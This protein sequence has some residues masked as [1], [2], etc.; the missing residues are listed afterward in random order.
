MTAPLTRVQWDAVK[1]A[2][3]DLAGLE[4]D[5]RSDHLRRLERD[6]PR[7]HAE[8]VALL[9]AGDSVGE[10]F[11]RGARV[12]PD[13][14]ADPGLT[15]HRI[16]AWRI[17]DP[18]GRGGMGTVYEAFRTDQQYEQRAAFKTLAAA[19]QSE[20]L[21]RRFRH[22][23]QILARLDHRNIATLLDG[24]VTP[25]GWPYFVMEFVA[26]E[27]I[28]RWCERRQ[29][30]VTR[31]IQLLRQVCAAVQYAHEHLVIHRDLK[32]GNILVTN[33]GS[34][35]LLDFGIAKLLEPGDSD[36]GE[37]TR[38][39]ALPMTAAYASPEQRLG[40]PVST[41][42]D[43]YSLGVVLYQLLAGHRPFPDTLE[44]D[45]HRLPPPPSRMAEDGSRRR[46]LRGD[47]D[48]IVLKCLRPE[49]EQ[50]YRSAQQL[51]EDLARY[52]DGL[53]VQARTGALGYR[54]GKFVRRN[55]AA[56]LGAGVAVVGLLAGTIVSL[57]QAGIARNERDRAV[58]EARR[59]E[60]V[61]RFFQDILTSAAPGR[62]GRQVTV[63]EAIDS[64]IARSDSAFR[65]QPDLRAAL[66]L[67]L[68]ATLTDMYL[69]EPAR[70]LLE[71]AYRIR[72]RLDGSRPSRAQADALYDLADIENQV[73][74]AARA[75]SLYRVSLAMLGQAGADSG[76]IYLG[77]SNIAESQL[78][79]GRLAEAAALY[80]TVARALDRLRPDNVEIRAITRANRGTALAQLGRP[81][82]AEPAL[83][84]AV[85]LFEQA[86]GT[87]DPRVASALQPL[88][89]TLTLLGRYVEAESAAFRAWQIDSAALGPSNAASLS[90]LR[91]L[92]GARV[93][94][95]R[96]D[97]AMPDI[98]YM[99]SLRGRELLEADPTLG[100]ALLQLGECRRRAGDLAAAEAALRDA[101][102]VRERTFPPTHWALAQAQSALGEVLGQRGKDREAERLLRDGYTGLRRELTSS[103]VRTVEA[104]RRL[105]AFLTARRQPGEDWISE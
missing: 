15:G 76:E 100:V 19:R 60:Q 32:P 84:E 13:A 81:A 105:E 77:L 95:G 34:V 49:P 62:Q 53:P 72:H 14:G 31:R 58:N 46:E 56:V 67:T 103:H 26:G 29:A 74:D 2:Y 66:M 28:D 70:P 71:E 43:V 44:F 6:D 41:A 94:D 96:C 25:E 42:S 20:G 3:A 10:R 73:G 54:M 91:M 7:V 48:A 16:G 63:T 22:E 93:E 78:T 35:K 68:G 79:Q 24:G 50:R 51:A 47:L 83:R 18:I 85:R 69:Y 5:A 98:R 39:G 64:A 88:A 52:L 104:R 101:L 33:D 21:L 40:R 27:P 1:S 57:R 92:T 90:V 55:R 99:L 12:W 23:R 61:T 17:G 86:R 97:L 102:A 59:T 80:D 38:T 37:L 8:V 4:P 9:A 82:E 30:T 36:G 65:D 89:G 87:A 45:P 11:E 75:E